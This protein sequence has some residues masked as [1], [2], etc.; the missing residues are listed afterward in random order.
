[1][2]D[3]FKVFAERHEVAWE[4]AMGALALIWVALGF[5]IDEIGSGVRSDLEALELALTGVFVV[6]FGSRLL[7]AHDRGRYFR[8]HWI[9]ARPSLRQCE[10]CACCGCSGFCASCGRSRASIGRPCTSRASPGI[11]A[12]PG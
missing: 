2:R 4:L 12:S 3:R 7:A 5:L 1:M 8:G 10:R 11:G 9:D 6:E